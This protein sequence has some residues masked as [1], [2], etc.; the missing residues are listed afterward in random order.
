MSIVTA[1]L[2]QTY[3]TSRTTPIPS[4][5]SFRTKDSPRDSRRFATIPHRCE[6]RVLSATSQKCPPGHSVLLALRARPTT[7]T[8]TRGANDKTG[9][10]T[11]TQA[12]EASERWK[13]NRDLAD[14][15][16]LFSSCCRWLACSERRHLKGIPLFDFLLS[17]PERVLVRSFDRLGEFKKD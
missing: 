7:E 11:H 14:Q 4:N 10:D 12:P 13:V 3:Q 1:G 15:D 2:F 9:T 6:L 5:V 8:T 16:P 17:L